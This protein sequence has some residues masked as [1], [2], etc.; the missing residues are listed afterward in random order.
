MVQNA[1]VNIAVFTIWSVYILHLTVLGTSNITVRTFFVY[2]L[3]NFSLLSSLTEL[4]YLLK[5]I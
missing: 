4:S 3:F 1:L 2:S 5:P